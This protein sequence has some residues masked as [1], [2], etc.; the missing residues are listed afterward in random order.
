M[1]DR[2]TSVAALPTNFEFLLASSSKV[3]LLLAA[4][5]TGHRK[6]RDFLS[7]VCPGKGAV[8]PPSTISC[9]SS[10]VSS[11]VAAGLP[12]HVGCLRSKWPGCIAVGQT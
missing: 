4:G 2:T 8:G 3:E 1:V 10:G 9:A 5:K 12:Y 11:G 6:F 7:P